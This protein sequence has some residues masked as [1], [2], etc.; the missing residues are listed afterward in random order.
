M[1]PSTKQRRTPHH[2][3]H[4]FSKQEMIDPNSHKPSHRLKSDTNQQFEIV[5]LA[6]FP[7]TLT[8]RPIRKVSRHDA[9]IEIRSEIEMRHL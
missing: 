8:L 3:F 1:K 6:T 2:A 9:H 4:R 5:I 7:L